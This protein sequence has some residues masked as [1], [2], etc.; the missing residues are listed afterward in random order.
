MGDPGFFV[1]TREEGERMALGSYRLE[2]V[3]DECRAVPDFTRA[4]ASDL[5][6]RELPA[7]RPRVEDFAPFLQPGT[8]HWDRFFSQRKVVERESGDFRLAS[9]TSN[10]VEV[11]DGAV[12]FAG[13]QIQVGRKKVKKYEV[14]HMLVDPDLAEKFHIGG[15]FRAQ[16]RNLAAIDTERAARALQAHVRSYEGFERAEVV[17]GR[18]AGSWKAARE[19]IKLEASRFQ[20]TSVTTD[21]LFI[22]D[23][24]FIYGPDGEDG[25]RVFGPER[26]AW[27]VRLVHRMV[28][29]T[30][31][32]S[33][34]FALGPELTILD[35]DV[36]NGEGV[37]CPVRERHSGDHSELPM[38]DSVA[39]SS[40]LSFGEKEALISACDA[41]VPLAVG[42]QDCATAVRITSRHLL[43]NSHVVAEGGEL[44]VNG[45]LV[46]P[47]RMLSKDLWIA[48]SGGPGPAWHL[49]RPE[50]GE[51]VV[52][53]YRRHE[54]LQILGPIEVLS[55]DGEIIALERDKGML[56]GVSGGAVVAMSDLAL[57]GVYDGVTMRRGVAAAFTAAMYTDVCA[58]S[59][60]GVEG[61]ASVREGN[62]SVYSQLVE[63]G[64][65]K[66]LD[67][68]FLST[69]P[70]YTDD[71]HVGMGF[72]RGGRLF[73]ACDPQVAPLAMG[74]TGSAMVF[75]VESGYYIAPVVGNLAKGP[76]VV[77][78]PAYGEKAI[79]L[80]KDAEGEYFSSKIARVTHVGVGAENFQLMGLDV[81]NALPLQGGLVLSLTDCAVVGTYFNPTHDRKRGEVVFCR[82]IPRDSSITPI[83]EKPE[84]ALLKVFPFLRPNV[85]PPGLATQA[86]THDS[87]NPE[88]R[89]GQAALAMVGDSAMRTQL[90]VRLRDLRIPTTKW[91]EIIQRDQSNVA[92]ARVC[93]ELGLGRKVRIGGGLVLAKGAKQY[94]DLL[95]AV[96][97]AIFLGDTAQNFDTFC[98]VVQAVREKYENG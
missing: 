91:Q 58:M 1:N 14:A 51:A 81:R 96:A 12:S 13:E 27:L 84:A 45:E 86:V 66:Q 74:P 41:C 93:E 21:A 42:G 17:V 2:Q 90:W 49:R 24:I 88:V 53:C 23:K 28:A 62:G 40:M 26:V 31:C 44:T 35:I 97:G 65:K 52:I 56:S 36:H 78:A 77:R 37:L 71:M 20:V 50:V 63:R 22:S 48:R 33:V 34:I 19:R 11:L 94:A 9:V 38:I 15:V 69:H 64:F 85:W 32:A 5:D 83:E 10:V 8:E 67:A 80:G 6:F 87:A 29:A 60:S 16:M 68:A 75:D 47:H 30:S 59:D 57:L 43:V 54:M 95:E 55:A 92:Q 61:H 18:Y 72:V 3:G 73:T 70:L 89:G 82:A 7:E 25:W 46:V 4:M 98:Q 79:I 39:V 76:A